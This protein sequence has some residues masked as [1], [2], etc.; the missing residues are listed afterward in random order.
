MFESFIKSLLSRARL[1]ETTMAYLLSPES[2][3]SFR[4]AFTHKSM[5]VSAMENYELAE[6]VGDSVINA[7]IIAYIRARFP[8][9]VNVDWISRLKN[10]TVSKEK[11]ASLADKHGFLKWIRMADG[12]LRE[13]ED[14]TI[15]NRS[16]VNTLIYNSR[17]DIN[18]PKSA[19]LQR[20]EDGRVDWRSDLSPEQLQIAKDKMFLN[21]RFKSLLEDTMEA[22]C[23][24]LQ[25]LVDKRE[26]ERHPEFALRGLLPGP[27]YAICAYL[28]SSFLDEI[29]FSL[30]YESVYDAKSR[31][32]QR[33]FDKFNWPMKKFF[34]TEEIPG[35]IIM[36][37]TQVSIPSSPDPRAHKILIADVSI[38]AQHGPNGSEMV[39]SQYALD[40]LAGKKEKPSGGYLDKKLQYVVHPTDP[41]RRTQ[42][43]SPSC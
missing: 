34:Y 5:N 28:I 17:L 9:V 27:G 41:Y 2:L 16:C 11:L 15:K 33:V 13:D 36:Y 10:T 40:V 3:K 26:G 25:T 31:L 29:E 7:I 23:G 18:D 12:G 30:E 22:F 14:P 8:K 39:A 20:I 37:R 38:E 21:S 43:S 42:S 4:V 24:T 35:K 32:K 6:L 1:T 19:T